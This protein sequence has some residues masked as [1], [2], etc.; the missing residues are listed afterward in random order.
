MIKGIRYYSLLGG[1]GYGD[2]AAIYME[3]LLQ[4]GV[5]L[6]WS[7]L[8]DTFWG[9]APWHLLPK[10]MRPSVDE[11]AGA[12]QGREILVECLENDINYDTVFLH[13]V[14]EQWPK[15]V[16]QDKLNIGYTV[17]ET[18]RLPSHWPT[19][20]ETVDH[21]CVPCEFNRDI[22]SFDGGPGVSIVPHALPRVELKVSEQDIRAF[23]EEHGITDDMFVFYVIATWTPRKAMHETVAAFLQAFTG[24][25]NVCLL[26]KTSEMGYPLEYSGTKKSTTEIGR[27]IVAGY[28]NPAKVEIISDYIDDIGIQLLHEIG[29]CFFSLT[30]CE[31]WGLGAFDAAATGNPVI[32]TGWGGQL[33]YLPAPDSYLVRFMLCAVQQVRDWGSY[34]ADHQW[35]CA[36]IDDAI[37]LLRNVYQDRLAAKEKGARLQSYVRRKFSFDQVAAQLLGV[38]NEAHSR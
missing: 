38:I 6:R 30:H 9:F 27:E 33:D 24:D 34:E 36:D 32:I 16:E 10:N 37:E 20:L 28:T 26:I 1:S 7:P 29:D 3:G 17:W 23:R 31:G 14:P 4:N 13:W 5:P 12:L 25:D 8:V 15:L 18:D 2:A 19:V 21:I 11:I 35:A 22:F